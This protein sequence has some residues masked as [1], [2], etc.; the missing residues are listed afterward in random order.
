MYHPGMARIFAFSQGSEQTW[1]H[2]F[3]RRVSAGSL[4]MRKS[5]AS[6]IKIGQLKLNSVALEKKKK[7]GQICAYIESDCPHI[8]VEKV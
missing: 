5:S 1:R 4:S 3:L 6:R 8:A 7:I 2:T